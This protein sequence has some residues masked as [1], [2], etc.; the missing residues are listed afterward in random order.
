VLAAVDATPALDE[1]LVSVVVPGTP[2]SCDLELRDP[3]GDRRSVRATLYDLRTVDGFSGYALGLRDLT[4]ERLETSIRRRQESLLA[5]AGRLLGLG[6]W[7]YDVASGR[8]AMSDELLEVLG[9]SAEHPLPLEDAF[10]FIAPED[11]A[12]LYTHA[13]GCLED[14]RPFDLEVEARDPAG[15]DYVLRFVGEAERDHTGAVVGLR[16]GVIDVTEQRRT[17]RRLRQQA[18]LLDEAG[19]AIVVMDVAGVVTFWN[20]AAERL[21]GWTKD[22]VLGRPVALLRWATTDRADSEVDEALRSTG[23][24]VGRRVH[25]DRHRREF[26]AEIRM[27]VLRDPDAPTGVLAFVRDVSHQAELEDRLAA[28]ERL[29]ALGTLTGGVAHDVNNLLT[30]INGATEMIAMQV[31]DPQV[32]T[33]TGIVLRAAD[34]GAQLAHRLLAF[35]RR[36]RLRPEVVDPI[37][38]V[39]EL[40]ETIRHTFPEPMTVDVE[41]P[42]SVRPVS[43]D[44]VQLRA[45][46]MNLAV[47]ARDAMDG[48]G[49]VTITVRERPG[50]GPSAVGGVAGD[51]GDA[52]DQIVFA[53]SDD[54][55]G[56]PPE[57][58]DRAFEPFF[59]TKA[60]GVGTG[61][62]LSMVFGFAR[63][64]G[65]TVEL[66]SEPGRGTTVEVVLPAVVG[67]VPS[68]S[69]HREATVAAEPVVGRGER[70]LVVEDEPMVRE[71]TAGTLR[72]LGYEVLE[73]GDGLAALELLA[74]GSRVD[75]VLSD[76]VMPGGPDGV[77][78]AHRIAVLRPGLP[79][80]LTS[81][82]TE[83]IEIPGDVVRDFLPKPYRAVQLA[84]VVRSALDRPRTAV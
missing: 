58:R 17:E 84:A 14:G 68:A 25:R 11:Q 75:L 46:L 41:H 42:D 23:V 30:V 32:A 70:V 62:G 21:Y 55:P 57:V 18:A 13:V 60:A 27:S 34:Q 61:L 10:A 26:L 83:G 39:D 6:G 65:G 47:N 35:G 82:Y 7:S 40:A 3:A 49:T 56:M 54:G 22:E 2:S 20:A 80:V 36:Q 5:I 79:V 53:V 77:E 1:V 15:D 31:D 78:L 33:L 9:R 19:D 8:L 81:G 48:G 64:S 38:V 67:A 66:R 4:R 50:S 28:M 12:R 76:V 44:L 71:Q 43:A 24:W 73:V 63:Q 52:G 69:D 29:E 72:R 45:A 51:A 59:T 16:G 37:A 74:G